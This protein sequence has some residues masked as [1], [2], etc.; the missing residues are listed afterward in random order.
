MNY[1]A[2]RQILDDD[3]LVPSLRRPLYP[4]MS[5]IP[6]IAEIP[7]IPEVAITHDLCENVRLRMMLHRNEREVV[8]FQVTDDGKF[9][10][11]R[12]TIKVVCRGR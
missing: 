8:S 7:E 11:S 1:L 12:K 9:F 10:G 4:S 6:T 5:M 3:L 2:R